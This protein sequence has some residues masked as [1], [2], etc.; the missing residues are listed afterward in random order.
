MRSSAVTRL[1]VH[2]D[3]E[4]VGR[5]RERA[6][7]NPDLSRLDGRIDVNADDR[8]DVVD[9]PFLHHRPAS[10]GLRLFRRLEDET[11]RA[12]EPVTPA[13]ERDRGRIRHRDMRIV[14]AGV[15]H[16]H[17][18]RRVLETRLLL[19][20]ECIEI[21]TDR[22][23]TIIGS[24]AAGDVDEQARTENGT[25][26]LDAVRFE[27]RPHP[28]ARLMLVIRQLGPTVDLAPQHDQRIDEVSID[29]HGQ[30]PLEY[31]S[32][33]AGHPKHEIVSTTSSD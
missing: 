16:P 1:A 26:R 28:A 5:R 9:V 8:V 21:R 20:G 3:V 11:H 15:H 22:D 27:P 31:S 6:G 2:R 7:P 33:G 29:Q 13:S 14:A 10:E 12:R 25:N 17:V 30:P 24:G 4:L 18:A 23:A 32:S 19:N